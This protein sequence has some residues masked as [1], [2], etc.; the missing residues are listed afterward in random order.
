M[1]KPNPIQLTV[2]S[3]TAITPNMQRIVMH[4]EGLSRFPA[5]CE[6]GYIKLMFTPDGST[7]LSSLSEG[8]RP[9]MR[10]YT[11]RELDFST[12][13]ITV[14]F[15][16]H[17]VDDCGCGHAARWAMNAK[18]GDTM[19]IAGPG[20]IQEINKEA[21]WF[22]MV[23]DMTALPALSVKIASLPEHA[24]GHAVI[25]VLS[26]DDIQPIQAP[27]G[28]QIDWLVKGEITLAEQV[29]EKVWL[30]GN[31]AIWCACEFDSMR[32]LRQY[33]RNERNVE[34]DN[35]YIS[36][37]WKNGVTEEGHKVIKREDAETTA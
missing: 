23:A 8:E 37:Y 22:F 2:E 36:S 5:N 13:T 3:T 35:I 20:T 25:E 29:K 31:A 34:R 12:H 4:G 33:F 10:T 24:K 28:M 21:D 15:V 18:V 7:D 6:G 19:T 26:Q 16:R 30:D 32:S 11:I 27:E 1:K 9:V 17:K 14:D